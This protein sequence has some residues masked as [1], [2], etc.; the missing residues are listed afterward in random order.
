MDIK[1]GTVIRQANVIGVVVDVYDSA[2]TGK[3]IVEVRFVKNAYLRQATELQRSD[4][5]YVLAEPAT[6]EDLEAEL[7]RLRG[8][9]E[10]DAQALVQSI[11]DG[12]LF[13]PLPK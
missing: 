13:K 8:V 5:F 7:T 4:I 3:R 6:I 2:H 10:A 11:R 12:T 1:P 9:A